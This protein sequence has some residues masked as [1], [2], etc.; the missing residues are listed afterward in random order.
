M[1]DPEREERILARRQR[2]EERIRAKEL[3][4]GKGTTVNKL[5]SQAVE[6]LKSKNLKLDFHKVSLGERGLELGSGG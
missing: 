4:E 2:V 6:R 5:W 3:E 1:G